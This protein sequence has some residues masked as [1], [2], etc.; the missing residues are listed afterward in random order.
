MIMPPMNTKYIA[1]CSTFKPIR[2]A[3]I[4][5]PMLAPTTTPAA[6]SSFISPARTRPM[7]IA[8]AAEE[9]CTTMVTTMPTST[10]INGLD[11]YLSMYSRSL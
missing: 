10:A 11:V 2:N 5:V 1:N 3:V 6:C 9:D 8:V 7:V 4:V